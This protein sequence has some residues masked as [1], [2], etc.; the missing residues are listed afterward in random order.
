MDKIDLVYKACKY[1][2]LDLAKD[3]IKMFVGS[4]AVINMALK[5]ACEGNHRKIIDYILDHHGHT[6]P[7]IN[8]G[9]YG[10]CLGNHILLV[11]KMI[12]LGAGNINEA[13]KYACKSGSLELVKY[14]VAIGAEDT[15]NTC[16]RYACS[17]GS[18]EVVKFMTSRGSNWYE[19]GLCYACKSANHQMIDLMIDY[20]A[21][22]LNNALTYA[23]KGGSYETIK[24]LTALGATIPEYDNI[25][26]YLC[27][28]GR[29]DMVKRYIRESPGIS[30]YALECGLGSLANTDRHMDL[31]SLLLKELGRKDSDRAK[32]YLLKSS[33]MYKDY[34]LVRH[35]LND[36]CNFILPRLIIL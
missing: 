12:S 24:Y 3:I 17:S 35:I 34:Q 27:Y 20:G 15:D 9:L 30:Q 10:A 11:S 19:L 1:G 36:V 13:L 28:S 4:P 18:I 2:H 23:Y 16:L 5:G 29:L 7:D 21:T 8:Y 26:Y 33:K 6:G 31:T 32:K 22:D 25:M 14:L